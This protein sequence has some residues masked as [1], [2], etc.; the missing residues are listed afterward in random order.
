MHD[1]ACGEEGENVAG[2]T[3]TMVQGF[4]CGSGGCVGWGGLAAQSSMA[5]GGAGRGCEHSAVP[6]LVFLQIKLR[7]T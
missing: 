1:T 4:S 2:L 5:L 3:Q 6:V 7:D